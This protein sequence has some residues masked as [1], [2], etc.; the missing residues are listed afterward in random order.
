M[1]LIEFFDLEIFDVGLKV[2]VV[3][4]F[5]TGLKIVVLVFFYFYG[6]AML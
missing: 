3:F 6:I 5:C 4:Y 2:V 1:I